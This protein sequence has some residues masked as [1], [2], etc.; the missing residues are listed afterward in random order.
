M[1]A[2]LLL[3]LPFFL[4]YESKILTQNS[5]GERC[6][7]AEKILL[8][9]IV[10]YATNET[11]FLSFI[12]SKDAKTS[13]QQELLNNLYIDPKLSN[14]SHNT[15]YALNNNTRRQYPFSI[16]FVQDSKTLEYVLIFPINDHQH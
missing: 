14:Y 15:L 11:K 9:F 12:A 3:M 1:K 4:R 16:I 2:I 8:N 5:C 13:F 7:I 10:D 6:L